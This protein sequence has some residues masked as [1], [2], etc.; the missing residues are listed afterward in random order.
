MAGKPP[1]LQVS[2]CLIHAS[3]SGQLVH[4]YLQQTYMHA[5]YVHAQCTLQVHVQYMLVLVDITCIF[6]Q[7]L[8]ALWTLQ[9]HVQ[10]MLVLW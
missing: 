1:V 4:V 8:H 10:Y 2:E 3:T 9:I 7:D 5:Y 6:T